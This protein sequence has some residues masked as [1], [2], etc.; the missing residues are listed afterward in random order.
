[1]GVKLHP[2]LQC[3]SHVRPNMTFYTQ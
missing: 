3:V 1:M 2:D